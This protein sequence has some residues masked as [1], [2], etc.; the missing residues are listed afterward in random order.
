MQCLSIPQSIFESNA[1]ESQCEHTRKATSSAIGQAAQLAMPKKAPEVTKVSAIPPSPK[2][3][4][5]VRRWRLADIGLEKE[6]LLTNIASA[7][8]NQDSVVVG[9]VLLSLG[10]HLDA[11]ID[12]YKLGDKSLPK[13]QVLVGSVRSS[14]WEEAMRSPP[15]SL[16]F[17]QVLNLAHALQA[18]LQGTQS[19][20]LTKVSNPGCIQRTWLYGT[21]DRLNQPC[22]S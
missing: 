20:Q 2:P 14:K 13:L 9:P 10:P 19:A 3:L 6:N 5:M 17:E 15:F 11:V 4:T 8:L 16:T 18:D 12:H 22:I 7:L 21:F 1:A